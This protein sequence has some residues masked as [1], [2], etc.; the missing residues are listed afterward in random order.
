MRRTCFAL[1][2]ALLAAAAWAT[3]A[4]ADLT[5]VPAPSVVPTT[6][7]A[8]QLATNQQSASSSAASTQVAPKN[9]NVSVRVLSPGTDG[10]VSQANTSTAIGAAGNANLTGQQ[11][12]QNGSGDQQ[13][14]QAAGSEQDATAAAESDQI[15]PQNTNVD[16]R[17]LSPGSNG[18]VSQ[19]NTSTAAAIAGNL[20]ATGQTIDQS[21]YG[22]G[23]QQTAGQEAGSQQDATAAAG[24]LQV[25]PSNTNVGVRVLS[26]GDDGPV[27]QRN[28]STAAAIAANL[29]ATKQDISQDPHGS[30]SQTAGQ[31][32][33]NWQGAN[34]SALS[35]QIHPSNTNVGTRVL[36]PGSGGSVS[37]ANT[38]TAIGAALNANLTKQSIDQSSGGAQPWLG[39]ASKDDGGAYK[40]D[41]VAVQ[42][43][44]QLA[45]N[46]QDAAA[47]ATSLQ[48]APENTNY[49]SGDSVKQ[50]NTSNAVG[51]AANLNGLG[52]TIGQ[53]PAEKDGYGK[54]EDGY[55]KAEDGYG[56][57]DD[58]SKDASA[59]LAKPVG[60]VSQS[61][62][63][64]ALALSGNLNLTHQ[65]ITQDQSGHPAGID[66]QAAGQ[67]AGN[68]Q[69]ATSTAASWQL[70]PTNR[71]GGIGV[72][73][74]LCPRPAPPICAPVCRSEVVPVK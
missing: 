70:A 36:S 72:L 48:V 22:P 41:G 15:K 28:D 51:I 2:V 73:T 43:A 7:T 60:G 55:G 52:Q 34:A 56:K 3:A 64:T 16:V 35:A 50:D 71:N 20:N 58:P 26:P 65:S 33:G 32:A 49:S 5:P 59:E 25:E 74:P 23:G 12:G 21:A 46:K 8:G 47:C 1:L 45:L 24:S 42:A 63:S 44:G 69:H 38:S 40:D 11:I 19:D 10:P 17:V 37:Q 57:A 14:G 6:Q 68:E 30:P 67:A 9:T 4:S 13:A 31:A 66:V 62:T 39:G 27:S 61:N 53:N 18:P 29:N 54:A